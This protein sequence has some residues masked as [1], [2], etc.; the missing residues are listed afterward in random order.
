MSDDRD[1]DPPPSGDALEDICDA[2]DDFVTLSEESF[3]RL[4]ASIRG[5]HAGIADNDRVAQ[6]RHADLEQL[7]R[8]LANDVRTALSVIPVLN[9][10]LIAV[11]AAVSALLSDD[12]PSG[13]NGTARN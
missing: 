9:S 12:E 10:R 7:V 2:L 1:T 8:G 5:I 13:T 3:D 11:E 4:D 6:A